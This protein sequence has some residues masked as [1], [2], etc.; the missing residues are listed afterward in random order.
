MTKIALI[1]AAP[2]VASLHLPEGMDIEAWTEIGRDLAATSQKVQWF[3][4]DWWAYG[5]QAYGARAAVAAEGIFGRS[6]GSLRNLAVVARKFEPSRRRDG[7]HFTHHQEV[8][9]LEPAEADQVLDQATAGGWSKRDVRTEV[10]RRRLAA[11]ESSSPP[12]VPHESP[13][14]YALRCMTRL[15]A[16]VFDLDPASFVGEDKGSPAQVHARQVLF[17][18]LHTE[19]GFEQATIAGGLGRHRSTVGHAIENITELREEPEIDQ[20]FTR[21]GEMYRELRDARDKVPLLVE[22]LAP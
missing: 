10:L 14:G 16:A 19:A 13:F 9:A 17:Y 8:A 15:V 11:E 20:A 18:L 22:A 5:D 21:L 7:V 6:Y 12:V 4:G 1:E 2:G 3:L